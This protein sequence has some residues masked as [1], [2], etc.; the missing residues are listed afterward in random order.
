MRPPRA[1][2]FFVTCNALSLTFSAG[3]IGV[4]A[5]HAAAPGAVDLKMCRAGT[6]P[7]DDGLI[8]DFE[9]GNNQLALSG[10][11]DGYWY[12]A[13]DPKGSTLA[14]DPFAPSDGGADGS[15]MALHASGHTVTGSETDAWGAQFGIHFLSGQGALYDA[16]KYVGIAFKAR[17]DEKSTRTVRFKIGDV[18]THPDAGQCKTCWNHFGKDMT[19]TP[20]WKEYV[21]LF[22]EAKQEEGWGDPRPPSLTP[23]K[24][25]SMDWTV[26]GG[27]QNFDLWIDDVTFVECK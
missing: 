8:D 15:A 12:S 26:K 13:H 9:D 25:L 23:T 3:C 14:P 4:S 5:K 7:A 1:L 18:N 10:G 24:L 2:V 16:S 6:R 17:V 22:S 21:V 19:F 20:K 11:R 27:G